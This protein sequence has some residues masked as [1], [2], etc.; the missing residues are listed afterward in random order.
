MDT[1]Q[2]LKYKIDKL[3]LERVAMLAVIRSL[4]DYIEDL[5]K[6]VEEF[7]QKEV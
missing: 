2:S 1:I 3:Q 5:K 7:E 6:I 4:A